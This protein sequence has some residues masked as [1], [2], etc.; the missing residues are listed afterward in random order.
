MSVSEQTSAK[1][2][3]LYKAPVLIRRAVSDDLDGIVALN[4]ALALETEGVHLDDTG[5]RRGAKLTLTSATAAE[6]N[7]AADE[8]NGSISLSPR[9]WVAEN[10]GDMAGMIGISPEWSDW[11]GTCYWWVV[12]VFV[13]SSHRRKGVGRQLFDTVFQIADILQADRFCH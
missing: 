4:K 3:R 2:A 9:F 13:T 5:V 10:E 7:E 12:S 1:K 6:E 8:D 11:H